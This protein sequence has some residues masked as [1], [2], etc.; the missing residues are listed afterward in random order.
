MLDKTP[1]AKLPLA[2]AA[3]RSSTLSN[4][5]AAIR[6]RLNHT[7]KALYLKGLYRLTQGH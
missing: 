6:V 2:L 1:A 3:K 5:R 7:Y 4:G